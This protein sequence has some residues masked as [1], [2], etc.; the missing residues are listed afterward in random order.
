MNRC[1]VGCHVGYSRLPCSAFASGALVVTTCIS[2][3]S[4]GSSLMRRAIRRPVRGFDCKCE[5]SS[6]PSI[7]PRLL[8]IGGTRAGSQAVRPV[9]LCIHMAATNGDHVAGESLPP[10][11]QLPT[12]SFLAMEVLSSGSP[13]HQPRFTNL[14]V[15]SNARWILVRL[16]L[17][18]PDDAAGHAE[19]AAPCAAR[20]KRARMSARR[21]AR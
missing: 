13:S 8:V 17:R 20:E 21:S 14:A 18:N 10:H 2:T 16:P 12:C 15:A 5:P 11:R 6:Q 4:R 9:R 3:I 19:Q 7:G 1:D